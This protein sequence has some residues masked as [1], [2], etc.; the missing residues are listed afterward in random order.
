MNLL[1]SWVNMGKFTEL[2]AQAGWQ[3]LKKK[4]EYFLG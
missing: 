1:P 2:K 3:R 4:L